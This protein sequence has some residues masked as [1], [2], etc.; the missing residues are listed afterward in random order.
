[1]MLGLPLLYVGVVLILNG[2]WLRGRIDDREIILIN[3][4][5]AGISFLVALHA[6]LFAQAVGDVRSAAMVLLFAITYLWVAYNRITGCD[7]RGLGWFCLI[8]AITVI[9]MAASTLAQGTGFM[10]IW[11]G[12]CWA[13]WAVLWF[14]YFLLLT[15]Q[16]PIL[17]QT[18]YFTLFCGVFTG[19]MPGMILLFSISK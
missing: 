1:M 7:G 12:L 8:V 14:M 19:W 4:C 2:L 17:K 16:M 3:L 11:L 15:V 6:A 18:A 5:V 9:P 13:A 10:F